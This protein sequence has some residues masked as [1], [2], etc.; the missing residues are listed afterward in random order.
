[1]TLQFVSRM[2]IATGALALTGGTAFAQDGTEVAANR[3]PD[4]AQK[5]LAATPPEYF[6][7][8]GRTF[9]R[10]DSALSSPE[11][12][13]TTLTGRVVTFDGTK[14]VEAAAKPVSMSP[15]YGTMEGRK[16]LTINH[17]IL[18][19]MLPGDEIVRIDD[20]PIASKDDLNRALDKLAVSGAK[21][22]F[23]LARNGLTL[24]VDKRPN[25]LP[26][27]VAQALVEPPPPVQMTIDWTKV[28]A[29]SGGDATHMKFV[30]LLTPGEAG[31][32]AKTLYYA[33]TETRDRVLAAAQYLQAACD[34]TKD[35]GF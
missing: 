32:K 9:A 11:V 25:L 3:T 12:C 26:R 17:A 21:A 10:R 7:P 28:Q 22:R 18:E 23:T 8:D 4:N 15:D 34:T 33:V 14:F 19:G 5:F 20:Q 16:F 31:S 13:T 6:T 27:V 29:V 1:M 35:L 2:M 24:V 30:G